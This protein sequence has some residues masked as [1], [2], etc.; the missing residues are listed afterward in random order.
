MSQRQAG[1]A[2][3]VTL[4]R[5][6]VR[7]ESHSFRPGSP[8]KSRVLKYL[9]LLQSINYKCVR[10]MERG[11]SGPLQAADDPPPPLSPRDP[12]TPDFISLAR[13]LLFAVCAR[14]VPAVSI[15]TK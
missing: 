14:S 12:N 5:S 7:F 8:A 15:I 11:V 3:A 2:G 6:H 10:K 13:F 4:K 9:E 1:K